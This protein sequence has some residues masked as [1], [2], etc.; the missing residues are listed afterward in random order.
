MLKLDGYQRL[1][2]WMASVALAAFAA[3]GAAYAPA[4]AGL[5]LNLTGEVPVVCRATL[6][7]FTATSDAAG[8]VGQLDEFCNSAAGYAVY[9]ELV[10]ADE[11]ATIMVDGEAVAHSGEGAVLISQ[12]SHA[13]VAAHK[14]ELA[15][16][17]AGTTIR[18]QVIPA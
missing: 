17:G 4:G 12:S 5:M 8:Y 15:G 18:L 6:N 7:E 3:P 10:G 13:N 1:T 2:H 9:I 14:L 11:N 16:V